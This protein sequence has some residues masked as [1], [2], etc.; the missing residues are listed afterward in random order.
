MANPVAA[1][2]DEPE[3]RAASSRPSPANLGGWIARRSADRRQ[4]RCS[5]LALAQT[6]WR[7]SGTVAAACP[8]LDEPGAAAVMRRTL[9]HFAKLA[10]RMCLSLAWNHAACQHR[11][12]DRKSSGGL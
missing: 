1:C 3:E 8:G 10:D 9:S 6:A 12:A 7:R 5:S 4:G 11:K 2:R